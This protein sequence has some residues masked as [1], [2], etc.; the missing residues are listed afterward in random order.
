MKAEISINSNL[1]LESNTIVEIS[2]TP[3]L[4]YVFLLFI[5]FFVKKM[6]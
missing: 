3:F 6:L 1:F 4:R 2:K 5:A